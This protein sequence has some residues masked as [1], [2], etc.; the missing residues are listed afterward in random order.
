MDEVEVVELTVGEP[1][2]I[3]NIH[4]YYTEGL[5]NLR[6]LRELAADAQVARGVSNHSAAPRSTLLHMHSFAKLCIDNAH[7]FYPVKQAPNA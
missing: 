2:P 5:T 3:P 7:E 6:V 4:E 1:L